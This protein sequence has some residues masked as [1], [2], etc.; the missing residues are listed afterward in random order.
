M[1]N[2]SLLPFVPYFI[3]GINLCGKTIDGRTHFPFLHR[4]SPKLYTEKFTAEAIF[5]CNLALFF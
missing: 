5:Q 2:Y 3:K 4:I 1:L